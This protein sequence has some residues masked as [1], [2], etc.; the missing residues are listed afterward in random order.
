MPRSFR[1]PKPFTT[2]GQVGAYLSQP[3]IQCLLCGA[4]FKGLGKHLKYHK[5]TA[6]QYRIRF[7]IPFT[8]GLESPDVLQ[9][10]SR[11]QQER[12]QDPEYA[13]RCAGHLAKAGHSAH[14]WPS[15][16]CPTLPDPGDRLDELHLKRMGKAERMRLLREKLAANASERAQARKARHQRA[17]DYRQA[18]NARKACGPA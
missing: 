18:Y 17:V 13:A 6:D 7:G 8:Y 10:K 11:L 15:R 3:R 9:L 14:T 5:V 2:L 4:A 12:L 16:R 1:S